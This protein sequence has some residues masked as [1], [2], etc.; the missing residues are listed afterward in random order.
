MQVKNDKIM[1][2]TD[3]TILEY[4]GKEDILTAFS[5]TMNDIVVTGAVS[6]NNIVIFTDRE[7]KVLS[8]DV[9]EALTRSKSSWFENPNR[10]KLP[11]TLL[12]DIDG[13]FEIRPRIKVKKEK[14]VHKWVS[15]SRKN[16]K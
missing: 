7:G 5:I 9:L 16:R 4:D 11:K 8:V 12:T 14:E 13:W 15:M 1:S 3:N 2:K 10:S 6:E